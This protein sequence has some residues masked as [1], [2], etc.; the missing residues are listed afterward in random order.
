MLSD[1]YFQYTKV[2]IMFE[3]YIKHLEYNYFQH[4]LTIF[5]HSDMKWS[6]E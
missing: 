1:S 6:Y 2:S 5:S 4:K 3:V